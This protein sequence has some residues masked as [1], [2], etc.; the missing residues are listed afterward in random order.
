MDVID[1]KEF[2]DI[3]GLSSKTLDQLRS[4]GYTTE[5]AA[6][7]I[8]NGTPVVKCNSAKDDAHA[9]GS[10]ASVIGSIGPFA[11]MR[12]RYGEAGQYGYWVRWNDL[13]G[14]PVFIA[15]HRIRAVA[16]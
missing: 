3:E 16:Q 10:L 8:E 6:G 11:R 1:P 14:T 9:D 12:A 5:Q 2:E 13:P 15:G 4:Q 7:A